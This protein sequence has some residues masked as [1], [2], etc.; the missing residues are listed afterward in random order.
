M[1]MPMIVEV[2]MKAL[3][4]TQHPAHWTRIKLRAGSFLFIVILFGICGMAH[5]MA[6]TKSG[7]AHYFALVD[8]RT[9]GELRLIQFI[10]TNL[11]IF[12]VYF[13]F[14]LGVWFWLG[15][16]SASR[17]LTILCLGLLSL[18]CLLYIRACLHISNKLLLFS[19]P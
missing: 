14:L 2:Q 11:W 9:L 17:F 10:Q 13:G 1:K 6:Q 4:A 8:D 15:I 3:S 5:F 7:L 16:R 12:G 18:P 19:S